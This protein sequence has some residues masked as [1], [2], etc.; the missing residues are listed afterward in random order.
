VDEKEKKEKK[1][2]KNEIEGKESVCV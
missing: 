2:K 1:E